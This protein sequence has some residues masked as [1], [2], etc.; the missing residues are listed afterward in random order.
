MWQGDMHGRG[1]H[2]GGEGCV[3]GGVCG[4][5][6]MHGRGRVWQ[7]RRPLQHSMHLTGMHSYYTMYCTHYTVTE[8]GTGNHCFL[9]CPSRSLSRAV[10]MSHYTH[11]FFA[12]CFRLAPSCQVIHNSTKLYKGRELT[13]NAVLNT[14][15]S[16]HEGSGWQANFG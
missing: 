15:F 4:R 16:T 1:V 10:C 12:T 6:G 13:V 8:T 5:G 2:G 14:G 7:E 9:L 11:F 3:A